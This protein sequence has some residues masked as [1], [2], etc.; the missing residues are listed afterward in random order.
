MTSF[1]LETRFEFVG[2]NSA[3]EK[4]VQCLAALLGTAN[5]DPGRLMPQLDP[6]TVE[7]TFLN[8]LF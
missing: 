2:Q 1:I 7:E 6:R 3:S 8:V 5:P 4:S